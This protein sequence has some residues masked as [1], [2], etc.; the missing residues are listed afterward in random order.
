MKKLKDWFARRRRD[1]RIKTAKQNAAPLREFIYLDEVSVYSLLTSRQGALATEYTDTLQNT[2]RS[3]ISNR[4]ATDAV[5]AKAELAGKMESSQAQTSQ[6]VRKSTVQ[7]AFKE[8]IEGEEDRLASRPIE[9]G[10]AVPEIDT[11]DELVKR[12][13]DSEPLSVTACGGV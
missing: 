6:V 8:L 2:T 5:I 1:R 12:Q 3:E 10:M 9:A 11:W 13:D 4:I 7:A